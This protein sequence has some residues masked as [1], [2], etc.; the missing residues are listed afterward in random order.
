MHCFCGHQAFL[1]AIIVVEGAS[2]AA[3]V[4]GIVF[5]TRVKE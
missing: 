3:L 2:L 4:L 1:T 5:S